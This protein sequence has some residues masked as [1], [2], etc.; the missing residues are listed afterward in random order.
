MRIGEIGY[1]VGAEGL[2]IIK[3]EVV[4]QTK[5]WRSA[6]GRRMLWCWCSTPREQVHHG[7]ELAEERG[8][9]CHGI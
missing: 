4:K 2:I 9:C 3:S 7:T 1:S 5:P 6:R 8:H